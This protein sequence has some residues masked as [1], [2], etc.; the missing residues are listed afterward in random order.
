MARTS[1]PGI[2]AISLFLVLALGSIAQAC[3]C[4]T[5]H[6]DDGCTCGNPVV[7]AITNPQP[8]APDPLVLSGPDS[9]LTLTSNTNVYVFDVDFS[10]DSSGAT[11]VDPVINVGDSITWIWV[12]GVHSVT[13]VNGSAES[14]NSGDRFGGP[15]FTH[16]F[17]QTGT[18]EYYCDIHGFDAGDGTAGGM[19]GIITVLAVPEPLS[20]A[21]AGSLLLLT[22]PRR[23]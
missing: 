10:T 13:S 12:S 8:P 16:T 6:C 19:A 9:A 2:A 15:N 22:L 14:F 20:L 11:I 1:N 3:Q 4:K 7:D 5:C 17:T 21:S 18:F 23:R